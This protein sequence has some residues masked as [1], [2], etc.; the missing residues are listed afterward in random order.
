LIKWVRS[1]PRG[2]P[3]LFFNIILMY[4]G[5]YALIP[6]L[7]QHLKH[8]LLWTTAL[9][10]ALLA[11]RQ[12]SQ[13]GITLFTGMLA[14][15]LG[16]KLMLVS[17]VF[18]R[19][20]GFSL[21]GICTHPTGFFLAAIVAGIGG[22]IFEPT[23]AAALT[24]LTPE[25]E[26][27]RMY[28]VKKLCCNLGIA[29]SALCSVIIM[30]F[31]FQALSI[32]CGGVY[33]VA[34][35][36]CLIRLPKIKV[37]ISPVPFGDMIRIVL[38]DRYFMLFTLINAGYY[39]MYMQTFLT[40]PM[41][42]VSLTHHVEAV[43]YVNLLL[44]LVIILGQY[45]VN[46]FLARFS[47]PTAIILGLLSMA[48]GMVVLG[49]TD[50]LVVFGC[51]FVLFAL[52]MMIVEP[53]AL[54]MTAKLAKPEVTESYFGFSLLALALGGGIGQGVGGYLMDAGAKVGF[55]SLIWWVASF[56]GVLAMVG[57]FLLEKSKG[58]KGRGNLV[59]PL[60]SQSS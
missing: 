47:L 27:G 43:F 7:T 29:L 18:I 41:R 46:R 48:C 60:T 45:P 58:S 53:T 37:Q 50:Q 8:D 52:G 4:M 14:D 35:I 9:A 21:F 19:G 2:V 6:Y 28:A 20:I 15:R 57:M 3:L 42:A 11:V 22:A 13:Q 24:A 16:Y 54:E 5:F 40:I 30:R 26:R 34:G 31:D 49:T 59:K 25:P 10:G 32:V 38:R 33:F 12:I 56:V 23:Q 36:L 55:P 1:F 39:F 17:G 44:A 51:G